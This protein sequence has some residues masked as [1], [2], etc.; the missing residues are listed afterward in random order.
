MIFR[1]EHVS[2]CDMADAATPSGWKRLSERMDLTNVRRV[3]IGSAVCEQQFLC[4]GE[5]QAALAESLNRQGVAV[6]LSVPSPR[7]SL[8]EPVKEK[9]RGFLLRAPAVDELVFNDRYLLE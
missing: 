6:S 7:Q 5:E 4:L 1:P 8:L 9:L 3:S 2:L